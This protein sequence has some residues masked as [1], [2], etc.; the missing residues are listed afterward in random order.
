MAAQIFVRTL[1]GST[2]P[3][4]LGSSDTV[5]DLKAQI[6]VAVGAPRSEQ[7]LVASG[8]P[9][10]C[11]DKL[12]AE[13]GVQKDATLHLALR[14]RGGTRTIPS[15]IFV[16]LMIFDLIGL[17][18]KGWISVAFRADGKL[19]HFPL[20]ECTLAACASNR[21]SP[22]LEQIF[23]NLTDPTRC[24]SFYMAVLVLT[25]SFC[26]TFVFMI[27]LTGT[28]TVGTCKQCM[29]WDFSYCCVG[30]IRLWFLI[31]IAP[32][33]HALV[34]VLVL[35]QD[36]LPLKHTPGFLFY[37]NLG[38]V[39]MSAYAA[40][41]L[42]GEQAYEAAVELYSGGRQPV[43]RLTNCACHDSSIG[44]SALCKLTTVAMSGCW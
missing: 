30:K 6:E 42:K 29:N 18:Q 10:S 12:V 35:I 38:A 43:V 13:Y 14:M 1:D 28:Y 19:C 15:L 2:L 24:P 27:Y 4:E 3:L 22:G 7:L 5:D 44:A 8:K 23:T 31:V 37:I 26:Y 9:L 41:V 17:T 36:G 40:N 16:F 25:A 21:E 20:S 39:L 34:A 33:A 32:I 11:G